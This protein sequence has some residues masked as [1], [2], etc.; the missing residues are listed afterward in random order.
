MR[1]KFVVAA[2]S[3][4][5]FTLLLQ[6]ASYASRD[7]RQVSPPIPQPAPSNYTPIFLPG[8][9]PLPPINLPPIGP[10][11]P[12]DGDNGEDTPEDPE[13]S[14]SIDELDLTEAGTVCTSPQCLGNINFSPLGTRAEGVDDIAA[15][16][17]QY[18]F[19]QYSNSE[20][21][22]EMIS[23]AR[24]H[25]AANPRAYIQRVRANGRWVTRT[26]C[27]RAVKDAMRDSGM[28]P[29][30]F[31]G[32]RHARDGGRDLEALGSPEF[33]NL[34]DN[35]DVRSLLENNPAMAPK[36]TIL[37]YE[38]APGLTSPSRSGHIEIKTTDSGNHGYISISET[39]QPTYGF[40]I[41]RVRRLTGVYY[42]RD[43][44][45]QPTTTPQR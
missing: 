14:G 44:A 43:L 42:R 29:R 20:T 36:G 22:E 33:I 38:N 9:P 12:S 1:M 34:L 19:N 39:N 24:A 17:L 3:A 11:N 13:D 35:P 16:T 18:A 8:V 32:T 7:A 2:I 31:Q 27:Y 26:L 10:I 25:I 40:A 5:V 21:V 15:A 45:D 37:V 28:V 23:Q 41:P 30:S 4:L 6:N